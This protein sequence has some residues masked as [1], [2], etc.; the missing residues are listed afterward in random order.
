[1][2]TKQQMR[3]WNRTGQ[4]KTKI[5]VLQ[6]YSNYKMC[7]DICNEDDIDVLTIDHIAGGGTKQRLKIFENDSKYRYGGGG[8]KF[9]YWLIKNKF[10]EGFRVL[11]RNCNWKE[12]MK[13]INKEE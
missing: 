2:P 3:K 10:P 1:M 6:V 13:N 4:F 8:N 11:C 9:Y 7:C 5:I 12:H